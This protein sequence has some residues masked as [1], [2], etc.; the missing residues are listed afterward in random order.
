MGLTWAE[1]HGVMERAVRR[2]LERRGE[3]VIEYL[4]VD[5]KSF[6]KQHEYVTVVCDLGA[7][8]RVLAVGD[9]RGR[10]S[11]DGFYERQSEEQRAGIKAVVMDMW[12]PYISSTLEHVPGAADKI[13]FDKFHV[14]AHLKK[15]IDDVRKAEHKQLKGLG[16]TT[17]TGTKYL[18]LMA[19][20]RFDRG[21]WV[22]FEALRKSDLRTA[23]AWAIVELFSRFWNYLSPTWARKLFERWYAWAIRSRLEP[24]KKVARMIKAH[25]PNILTY[26]RHRVTNAA[27]EGMNAKIQWIKATGRGFTNRENFRVAILF[28]CGG[29]DL[30]PH[31]I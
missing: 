3:E 31:T 20:R 4:G 16:D 5:E 19:R 26:L 1:V 8:P 21:A 28:H 14:V 2:G 25:L 13:V 15:A 24:I 17:L 7:R 9:G 11:L 27:T 30:Y 18:W 6:Q 29:L 12:G 23:R 10:A 22:D